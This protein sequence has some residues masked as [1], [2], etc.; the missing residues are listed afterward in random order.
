MARKASAEVQYKN[1]KDSLKKLTP[2]QQLKWVRGFLADLHDDSLMMAGIL[3]ALDM[4]ILDKFPPPPPKP[5]PLTFKV[6]ES[7]VSTKQL[8]E[9]AEGFGTPRDTIHAITLL[10]DQGFTVTSL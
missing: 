2:E 9:M 8:L 1:L 3:E 7:D 5:D 10:E 6:N 4:H